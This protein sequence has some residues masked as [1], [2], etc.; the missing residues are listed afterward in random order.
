M[1]K[2]QEK[3]TDSPV[4]KKP[5]KKELREMRALR[6]E[7]REHVRATPPGLI[8]QILKTPFGGQLFAHGTTMG[9]RTPDVVAHF[10]R[11]APKRYWPTWIKKGA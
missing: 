7:W 8:P 11:V 5:T 2:A 4:D 1:K 9:L 6:Q 10:K 3:V